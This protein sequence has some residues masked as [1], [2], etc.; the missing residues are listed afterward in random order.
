MR[1]YRSLTNLMIIRIQTHI[2]L[3]PNLVIYSH[4][5]AYSDTPLLSLWN[6]PSK[7]SVP[8]SS[9][10]DG[11]LFPGSARGPALCLLLLLITANKFYYA[12]GM[13]TNTVANIDMLSIDNQFG[14]FWHINVPD[15]CIIATI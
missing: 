12:F 15:F 6:I 3:I 9:A 8:P 7:T 4:F 5:L 11:K 10:F 2:N 1:V 13:T 14:T